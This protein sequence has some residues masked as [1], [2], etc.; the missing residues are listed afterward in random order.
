MSGSSRHKKIK[1]K[2]T[3]RELKLVHS[4]TRGGVDTLK[5]EEVK[6][7]RSRAPKASSSTL[8]THSSSPTKRAKLD[9]YGGD[10]IPF[11]LEDPDVSQKRKT[12]VSDSLV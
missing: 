3:V 4:V 8:Q 10:P 12:L 7:P 9:D 2:G 5:L 1:P 11:D 6:T